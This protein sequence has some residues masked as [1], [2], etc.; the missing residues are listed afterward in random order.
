MA[1]PE[2]IQQLLGFMPYAQ[3]FNVRFVAVDARGLVAEMPFA[4]DII[5][6]RALPALHGGALA[7]FMETVSILEVAYRHLSLQDETDAQADLEKLIP[8]PVNVTMQYLRSANAE[9]CR[10]RARVLKLGRR[11]TTVQCL[12]WQGDEAKPVTSMTGTFILR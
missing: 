1:A 7:G 6:N 11:A 5:G 4:E 9:A 10:A 2:M 8:V 12:L 3:A